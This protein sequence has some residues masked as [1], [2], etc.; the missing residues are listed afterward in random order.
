MCDNLEKLRTE[1]ALDAKEAEDTVRNCAGVI[2]IGT[3]KPSQS[4]PR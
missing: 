3:F 4:K 2:Y 1:G